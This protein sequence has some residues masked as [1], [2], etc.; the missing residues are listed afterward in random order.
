MMIKMSI[1][2]I[3]TNQSKMS[4]QWIGAHFHSLHIDIN[5]FLETSLNLSVFSVQG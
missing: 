1:L 4:K 5:D 3:Y 2:E